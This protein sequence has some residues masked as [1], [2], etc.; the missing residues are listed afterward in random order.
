MC[1]GMNDGCSGQPVS[2]E[3]QPAT[4]NPENHGSIILLQTLYGGSRP[5]PRERALAE[6]VRRSSDAEHRRHDG[7]SLAP[8]RGGL[9][10]VARWRVSQSSAA[11]GQDAWRPSGAQTPWHLAGSRRWRFSWRLPSGRPCAGRRRPTEAGP[12]M[13]A[14]AGTGPDAFPIQ[15]AENEGMPTLSGKASGS[16]RNT[17]RHTVGKPASSGHD[18]A[19]QE[20]E[21]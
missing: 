6:S 18:V 21:T 20:E 13:T 9:R 5:Q 7:R 14:H 16:G 2:A 4:E 11:R 3:T 8:R 19:P 1:C 17:R 10:A 15:T 12:A